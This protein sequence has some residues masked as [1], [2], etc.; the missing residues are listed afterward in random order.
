MR[1]FRQF[2][3]EMNN[4]KYDYSST[5]INLPQPLADKIISW[6]SETIPNNA[7][8]NDP[9]D[10]AFGRE[11]EIHITILYGIHSINPDLIQKLL[12]NTVPF[13]IT[14]GKSS[15]FTSNPQF[16]VIKLDVESPQL[17]EL[18]KKFSEK[19]DVTNTHPVYI[20][21]V[22]I[23]YLKKG[24]SEK[25]IGLD[26]FEGTKFITKEILFSSKLGVKTKLRLS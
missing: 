17:H 7:I 6:G 3:I 22:T 21:H 9:K 1:T 25:F 8:F 15:A 2:L 24:K 14:L 20:P 12:K 11:N 10:P 19:L 26:K 23:A 18:N 13:E 4:V 5:Q 16:D